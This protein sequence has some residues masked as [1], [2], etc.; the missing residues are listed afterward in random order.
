MCKALSSQNYIVTDF[1]RELSHC[2]SQQA[3][4][5]FSATNLNALRHGSPHFISCCSAKNIS[6]NFAGSSFLCTY[7][8]LKEKYIRNVNGSVSICEERNEQNTHIAFIPV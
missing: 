7:H 8:L 3:S 2:A 1:L 4:L 5:S 6:R